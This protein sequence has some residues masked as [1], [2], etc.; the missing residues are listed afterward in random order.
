VIK[1]KYRLFYEDDSLRKSLKGKDNV[2]FKMVVD[3][4]NKLVC[5]AKIVITAP[6]TMAFK[7]I[8]KGI[9]TVVIKGQ[10][11]LGNFADFVGTINVDYKEM[12]KALD[13][14]F[15][16][17]RQEDFIKDTLS[18]GIEYNSTQCYIDYINKFLNREFK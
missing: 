13:F 8:Q 7:S 2:E 11:M 14:Q 9:P 12:M 18:G 15:E 1:E 6:S 4:D 17:G 16:S 3:N 10:G 5:G